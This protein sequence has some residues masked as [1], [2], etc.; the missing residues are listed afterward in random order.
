MNQEA[1]KNYLILVV[2]DEK[3]VCDFLADFLE[4]QGYQAI[5]TRSCKE[6][7]RLLST[8]SLDLILLDIIMPEMNGLEFLAHLQKQ[9][10]KIPVIVITGSKDEN[11]K[12]ESLRLG[13]N[14]FVTKPIDLDHLE[15]MIKSYLCDRIS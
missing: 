9:N 7:L 14:E 5:T 12:E 4:F 3:N 10:N 8:R 6:A 2:D 13:A 11:V 1:S 15:R